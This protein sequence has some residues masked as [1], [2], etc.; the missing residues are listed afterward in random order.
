MARSV[1]EIQAAIIIN[2]QADPN[3]AQAASTSQTAIWRLWTFVVATAIALLEQLQDVFKANVE[4]TV[5]LSAPQTPQ[6][7]QDK[8]FK[9]QYDATTPQVLQL[10]DLVPQYPIVDATKLIITRCSVKSTLSNKVLV[11]VAKS[12]TPEPLTSPE[13]SA[14]QTYVD[15]LGVAGIYYT[16]S[17]IDS[18][19]IYI[20]ANIYYQGSYSAVIQA[21]VIAAIDAYLAALP[22]DG[23]F[24]LSDL[25][26][27]IRQTEGV[28][29]VVFNNVKARKNADSLSAATFLVQD[30]AVVGRTWATFAGYIVS[31]TTSGST[32]TD[33]LTFIAE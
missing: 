26:I 7:L 17:S 16:C 25:E 8:V 10:I 9:F 15:T 13:L 32:L 31:E 21:N 22:F 33:T 2:V 5:A 23:T 18:D 28:S 12:L 24:K 30:N 20:Q 3:L 1:A 19:K 6:W 11:K 4:S 14:L 27:V 29:D